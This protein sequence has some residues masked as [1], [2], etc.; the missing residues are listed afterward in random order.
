MRIEMTKKHHAFPITLLVLPCVALASASGGCR[1][2]ANN[3]PDTGLEE[4]SNPQDNSF[5][6]NARSRCGRAPWIFELMSLLDGLNETVALKDL[7][8]TKVRRCADTVL[9]L[10]ALGR[11]LAEGD[12]KACLSK[13]VEADK[14]ALNK[15]LAQ[16]DQVGKEPARRKKAEEAYDSCYASMLQ[17]RDFPCASCGDGKKA[18]HEVCDE[19]NGNGYPGHCRED[20]SGTCGASGDV[21]C[22]AEEAKGQQSCIPN[23]VC[24]AGKCEQC[25]SSGKQCCGSH[26]DPGLVCSA[27]NQ[28]QNPIPPQANCQGNG[29]RLP[30]GRDWNVTD[31]GFSGGG[32]PVSGMVAEDPNGNTDLGTL[33][34]D[35]ALG[36][37]RRAPGGA[38][39]HVYS[40]DRG[41]PVTGSWP[42]CGPGNEG[43]GTFI[44]TIPAGGVHGSGSAKIRVN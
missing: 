20:C 37:I 9:K 41:S 28:C 2:T 22:Q 34:F 27:S 26:C 21:C 12:L 10:K 13:E 33:P 43:P 25:G 38:I 24:V 30:A 18:D 23:H 4:P 16:L 19:G 7:M 39:L 3:R 36:A 40:R 32:R 14:D 44:F 1:K 42:S 6:D 15:I 29:V 11:S 35:G 5:E 17:C 8:K 31:I